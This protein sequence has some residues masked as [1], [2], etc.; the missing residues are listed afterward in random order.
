MLLYVT[1]LQ[2][3][4]MALVTEPVQIIADTSLDFG[5][6]E[7]T[8]PI[9][10]WRRVSTVWPGWSVFAMQWPKNITKL[11][12]INIYLQNLTNQMGIIGVE[13]FSCTLT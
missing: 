8:L 9:E 3:T 6:E 4:I 10:V 12:N 2:N 11:K 7:V 5:K 13:C 1:E